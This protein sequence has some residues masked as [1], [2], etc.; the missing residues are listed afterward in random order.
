VKYALIVERM[1]ASYSIYESAYARTDFSEHATG[2]DL[3]VFLHASHTD[4]SIELGLVIWQP[5]EDVLAH[6]VIQDPGAL[7]AIGY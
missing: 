3:D 7:V 2:K 1:H 4:R 5:E 6:S